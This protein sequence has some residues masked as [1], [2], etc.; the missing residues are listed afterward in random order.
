MLR[1][2]DQ[3]SKDFLRLVKKYCRSPQ[4]LKKN[5]FRSV[6]RMPSPVC[7]TLTPKAHKSVP[8]KL[9]T[10]ILPKA[11]IAPTYFDKKLLKKL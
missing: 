3:K 11:L 4:E 6:S 2:R 7:V 9:Y 1:K 10:P 5:E 8:R